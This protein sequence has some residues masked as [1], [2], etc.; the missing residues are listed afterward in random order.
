MEKLLTP[1]FV[2]KGVPKGRIY[3]DLSD[4]NIIFNYV[5][6]SVHENEWTDVN[7]MN[8]W[9]DKV[10]ETYMDNNDCKN[11]HFYY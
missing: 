4:S 3:K 10:L 2:F 9:I 7:V 6:F 8:Q 1:L 11:I 5:E